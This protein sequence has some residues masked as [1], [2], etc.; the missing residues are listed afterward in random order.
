MDT[1][2]DVIYV[3][4]G[5]EV[6][7][8]STEVVLL[9]ILDVNQIIEDTFENESNTDFFGISFQ[10]NSNFLI[11]DENETLW[12]IGYSEDLEPNTKKV[13]D[14]IDSLFLS[15]SNLNNIVD[16]FDKVMNSLT[17]PPAAQAKYD[18]AISAYL[19]ATSQLQNDIALVETISMTLYDAL[20]SLDTTEDKS[21]ALLTIATQMERLKISLQEV[22]DTI[23][24]ASA[25]KG[26]P[27]LRLDRPSHKLLQ[28]NFTQTPRVQ[29]DIISAAPNSLDLA[30]TIDIQFTSEIIGKGISL[31]AAELYGFVKEGVSYDPY[32]GS[33]K[34]ASLTMRTSEDNVSDI[35]EITLRA[36]NDDEGHFVINGDPNFSHTFILKQRSA[37]DIDQASL[38]IALLRAKGIPARYVQ[39]T[40]EVPKDTVA[41]LLNVKNFINADIINYTEGDFREIMQ[42]FR[43]N[44]IP[45]EIV[46]NNVRFEHYWVAVYDNVSAQWIDVDPSFNF[47]PGYPV[48]D[49]TFFEEIE[50]KLRSTSTHINESIPDK[51]FN[52]N[53]NLTRYETNIFSETRSFKDLDLSNYT[54]LPSSLPYTIVS[55]FAEY[56]ELP[57]SERHNIEI[58][59]IDDTGILLSYSAPSFELADSQVG[60]RFNL[61]EASADIANESVA[62]PFLLE[63]TPTLFI[64]SVPVASTSAAKVGGNAY[65]LQVVL[66]T[67]RLN[68][69]I[70]SSLPSSSSTAIVFDVDRRKDKYFKDQRDLLNQSLF[71]GKNEDEKLV[72]LLHFIGLAYFDTVDTNDE[73]YAR[74][75]LLNFWKPSTSV[76]VAVGGSNAIFGANLKFIPSVF[77]DVVEDISSVNGRQ[78]QNIPEA[79]VLDYLLTTGWVN[80]YAESAVLSFFIDPLEESQEKLKAPSGF[81]VI[82]AGKFLNITGVDVTSSSI[83]DF[84]TNTLIPTQVTDTFRDAVDNGYFIRTMERELVVEGKVYLAFIMLD[85]FGGMSYVLVTQ[86]QYLH[87]SGALETFSTMLENAKAAIE[88]IPG[89]KKV[90]GRIRA[91]WGFLSSMQEFLEKASE[92]EKLAPTDA[93]V[94][95]FLDDF[96]GFVKFKIGK[97]VKGFKILGS[98][99]DLID[100]IKFV[101]KC[102]VN[103]GAAICI[104]SF[105]IIKFLEAFGNLIGWIVAAFTAGIGKVLQFIIQKIIEQIIDLILSRVCDPDFLVSGQFP[106]YKFD[107]GIR[108]DG[109]KEDADDRE[110]YAGTSNA[111]FK[112]I[113]FGVR[114]NIMVDDGNMPMT[115]IKYQVKGMTK[116]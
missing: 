19:N 49:A 37:N 71:S 94:L 39:G 24:D 113:V 30:E 36:K 11:L 103:I 96:T 93:K 25:V 17:I 48:L 83:D 102:L 66:R 22:R 57:S 26:A 8:F 64:D 51:A 21:Q 78:E 62:A 68:R 104:A 9:D 98:V 80:A 92:I 108:T 70:N 76:A 116:G 95:A 5:R 53:A 4:T 33:L 10:K 97:V 81:S 86:N 50:G 42:T 91:V 114:K 87:G 2:N 40:I 67:P 65:T 101:S 38:L 45:A 43:D 46:G 115:K 107:L 82:L 55:R 47:D 13:I 77:L 32:Y 52:D 7:K 100:A 3:S 6:L 69:T 72:D 18:N 61:T 109:L 58:N 35:V 90:L 14:N 88:S 112:E 59:I 54:A 75:S 1:F 110:Y 12:D 89:F 44:G 23:Y 99:F 84:V 56:S 74:R 15:T 106:I 41:Q 20:I 73:E 79:A 29:S 60:I 16:V 31:T 28:L 63:Y 34:G 27:P 111:C 85:N 105:I